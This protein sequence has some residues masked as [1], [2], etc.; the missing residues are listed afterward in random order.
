MKSLVSVVLCTCN[1]EKYIKEQIDSILNQSYPIHELVIQD[2]ASNDSTINILSQYRSNPKVKIYINTKALGFNANFLSAILKTTGDYIAC[3][4]QDDIWKVNKI[5]ELINN[6]GNNMLI[7]HDSILFTTD[8]TQPLGMRNSPNQNLHET[9]LLLKPYIPGHQCFFSN[10]ILSELK[11]L[12]RVEPNLS[13][14]SLICLV[15]KA[16]GDIVYR[17]VGLIYWRRHPKAVSYINHPQ[18]IGKLQGFILACKSLKDIEKRKKTKDYFR[19]VS[20]VPLKQ[21]SS[22]CIVKYMKTGSLL[23]IFKACCVCLKYQKELYPQEK[24]FSSSLK[25]FLIP[26]YFIRD[27][28]CFIIRK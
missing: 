4:D 22:I 2:D 15:S 27:S 8:I 23:D 10:K 13:Y 26:L 19:L 28:S 21:P 18:R 16:L 7:F 20:T 24:R 17:D 5:E 11:R 14:D 6:I 12:F 25:T 9:Y 1:G 3:S